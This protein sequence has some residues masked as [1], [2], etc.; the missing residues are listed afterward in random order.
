MERPCD[1]LC[2][3]YVFW[4]DWGVGAKIERANLD[5]SDRQTLVAERVEWPTGLAMD[6]A[7][8]RLYW[9]DA[10]RR[11]IETITLDGRNRHVVYQM[12]SSEYL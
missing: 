6:Y 10:R 5:G 11:T 8:R 1:K 9:A 2:C 12:P 7:N 3:R 4:T